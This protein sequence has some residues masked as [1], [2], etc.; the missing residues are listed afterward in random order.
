MTQRK[1]KCSR[2]RFTDSL[3]MWLSINIQIKNNKIQVEKVKGKGFKKYYFLRP[4]K[5]HIHEQQEGL[6]CKILFLLFFIARC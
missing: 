1:I 5:L 4:E 2:G 6:L 3:M